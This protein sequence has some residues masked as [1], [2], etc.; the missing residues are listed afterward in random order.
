MQ[1]PEEPKPLIYLAGMDEKSRAEAFK[2]AHALRN[3]GISAEI[4]HMERSVKAQLKFADKLGAKFVAV[5]GESELQSG[6]VN[7]KNMSDGSAV[8]VKIDEIRTYLNK[9]IKND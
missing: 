5:I 2:I 1:F 4:D 7:L 8:A 9:E 6:E 3:S